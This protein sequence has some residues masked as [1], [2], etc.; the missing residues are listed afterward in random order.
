MKSYKNCFTFVGEKRLHFWYR[1]TACESFF[2]V[3]PKSSAPYQDTPCKIHPAPLAQNSCFYSMDYREAGVD[4]EA[5]RAFVNQI[6]SLVQ[7]T[8]RP[9]VLG[10][11]GGFSGCFQLPI[12]YREPV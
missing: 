2:P 9:E 8:H 1:L 5:G 10:G 11:L 12:G 4:V 7:S 3:F 6:R